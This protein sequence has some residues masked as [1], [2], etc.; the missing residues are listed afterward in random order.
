MRRWWFF[1]FWTLH[2]YLINFNFFGITI[3]NS[4]IENWMSALQKKKKKQFSTFSCYPTFMDYFLINIKLLLCTGMCK[5]IV[6]FQYI[7]TFLG[8]SVIV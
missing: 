1:D 2:T 6:I 4:N 8:H 7:K 3:F 5:I